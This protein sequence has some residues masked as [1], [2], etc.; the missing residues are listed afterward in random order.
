MEKT[1]QN[2]APKVT[3]AAELRELAAS[4]ASTAK[5]RIRSLFDEGTFAETGAY[6]HRLAAEFGGA[7]N[8]LEGV[9]TGYGAIDGRLV[10]AFAQDYSRM[11]GAVGAM[12]AKKI[13]DMYDLA[14]KNGAPVIGIFDSAGAYIMEGVEAL[15]GYGKIMKKVSGASGIIPQIAVKQQGCNFLIH[16]FTPCSRI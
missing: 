10:F 5:E 12:H 14:I 8:E 1:T 16:R 15:A 6:A 2:G 13:A 9:I 11:K 3:S 7:G 4:E